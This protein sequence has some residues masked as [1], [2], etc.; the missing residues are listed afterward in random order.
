[1]TAAWKARNPYDTLTPKAASG[2]QGDPN[3]APT[4]DRPEAG[5]VSEEDHRAVSWSW[6]HPGVTLRW[7]NCETHFKWEPHQLAY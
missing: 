6:L 5:C 3:G 7:S 4:T 2:T 1:M